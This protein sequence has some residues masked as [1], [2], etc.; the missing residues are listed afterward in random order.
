MIWCLA[1][2]APIRFV[3]LTGISQLIAFAPRP[4]RES[5]SQ[6]FVANPLKPF[7]SR[8]KALSKPPSCGAPV[9]SMAVR[10]RRIQTN[11]SQRDKP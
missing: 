1:A 8:V 9:R 10:R 7:Y 3:L 5:L 6:F 11:P 4:L 2:N